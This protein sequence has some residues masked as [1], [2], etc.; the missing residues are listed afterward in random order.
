MESHSEVT[1]LCSLSEWS[2]QHIRD[3]FEAHSEE[4]CLRAISSTFSDAVNA[5]I[6]GM[7]LSREGIN[8][9]VLAMRRSSGDGLK[10][11][12]QQTMEV[13]RDAATNRVSLVLG[14]DALAIA[15][16]S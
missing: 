11:Q 9:L 10:V 12:W 13:P 8:H 2:V 4:K 14:C 7:S 6:N 15:Y 16:S 5:S 3:V 1:K